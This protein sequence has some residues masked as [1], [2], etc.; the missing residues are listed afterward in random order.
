MRK[1]NGLYAVLACV[2]LLPVPAS[3]GSNSSHLNK[4]RLQ[5]GRVL[6]EVTTENL[7]SFIPLPA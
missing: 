3:A 6:I 5:V 4:E 7:A 2:I 1:F